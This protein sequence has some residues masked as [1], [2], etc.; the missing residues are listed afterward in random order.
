MCFK[1]IKTEKRNK[2]LLHWQVQGKI[3]IEVLSE[4]WLSHWHYELNMKYV[5]YYFLIVTEKVNSYEG[6]NV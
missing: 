5:W 2:G 4:R 3:I 1:E 6:Y